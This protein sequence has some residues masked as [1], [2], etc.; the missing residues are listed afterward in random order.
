MAIAG[1]LATDPL[2]T[3]DICASCSRLYKYLIPA[4]IE[5]FS[6]SL[7]DYVA[8]TFF[9]I[10]GDAS[11]PAVVPTARRDHS[12]NLQSIYGRDVLSDEVLDMFSFDLEQRAHV[13]PDVGNGSAKKKRYVL[14]PTPFGFVH[15]GTACRYPFLFVCGVRPGSVAHEAFGLTVAHRFDTL[16]F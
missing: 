10:L 7:R 13:T 16:S 3:C 5:A 9:L 8:E 14:A 4:Y 12:R 1:S 6:A 11:D 2:T 15:R